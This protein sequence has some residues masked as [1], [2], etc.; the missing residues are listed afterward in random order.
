M[1]RVLLVD[2][3]TLALRAYCAGLM[4]AGLQVHVATNGVVALRLLRRLD[5]D[6]LVLELLMP[7]CSGFELLRCLN[8]QSEFADLAVVILSS[9]DLGDTGQAPLTP[10][11]QKELLKAE[12]AP[13]RLALIVK[14]LLANTSA[15]T[16]LASPP[17]NPVG[18]E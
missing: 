10:H 15:A 11:C 14:E 18:M 16:A 7:G 5:I 17:Y 4:R 6:V 12:C 3:D 13:A 9:F 2:N 8:R 1:K